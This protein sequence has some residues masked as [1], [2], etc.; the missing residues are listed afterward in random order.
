MIYTIIGRIT[1][2]LAVRFLRRKISPRTAALVGFGAV[3]TVTAVSVAGY[4]VVRDVPE[5]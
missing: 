3:A 2:K 4:L 1:V 5:A